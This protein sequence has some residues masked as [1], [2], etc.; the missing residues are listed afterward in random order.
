MECSNRA[1]WNVVFD[2]ITREVSH[3]KAASQCNGYCVRGKRCTV[4]IFCKPE[5]KVKMNQIVNNVK[6]S[7]KCEQVSVDRA[8]M[9]KLLR[10]KEYKKQ[11]K[12]HSG[13]FY[14]D[15]TNGKI[16]YYYCNNNN[17]DNNQNE[18]LKLVKKIEELFVKQSKSGKKSQNKNNKNDGNNGCAICWMEID[19][20]NEE[21]VRLFRCGDYVHKECFDMQI[22]SGCQVSGVRPLCCAKCNELISLIDI[23]KNL[24]SK[25][26]F[27]S[28]LTLCC[29]DYIK[30]YPTKYRHC[31]TPQCSQIYIN[32]E[33]NSNNN[34]NNNENKV[35]DEKS[36]EKDNLILDCQECLYQYCLSCQVKY[37]FGLTCQQYIEAGKAGTDESFAEFL[38]NY[39]NDKDVGSQTCPNCH[40]L[41]D[42]FK[43][44]CNHAE[45]VYC[46]IHFCWKC[47]WVDPQNGGSIYPHMREKHGGMYN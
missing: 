5:D 21:I 25:D 36:E 8:F 32:P 29:T 15:I 31:P 6:L 18:S 40:L 12:N 28:F 39:R 23:S 14:L 37:H 4:R 13:G 3:W 10:N 7:V 35:A 44:T 9:I 43:N 20:N 34:N 47:R 22:Q 1:E 38:K 33:F 24:S 16:N 26:D 42:K 19:A 11:L 2:N 17:N 46:Q 45:C 27:E 30:R 41:T